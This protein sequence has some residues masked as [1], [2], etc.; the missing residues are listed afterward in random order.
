MILG[1]WNSFKAF[2]RGGL[3][4]KGARR[5]ERRVSPSWQIKSVEFGVW[6]SIR[7]EGTHG[8]VEPSKIWNERA[9]EGGGHSQPS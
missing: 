1:G 7:E 5:S 9:D 4:K 8:E 6:P 3:S 2:A